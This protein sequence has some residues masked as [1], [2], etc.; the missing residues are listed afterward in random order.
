[1]LLFGYFTK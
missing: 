1:V